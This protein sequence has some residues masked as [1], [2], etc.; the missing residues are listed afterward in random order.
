MVLCSGDSSIID[1]SPACRTLTLEECGKDE[2]LSSSE[3]T[4]HSVPRTAEA[5]HEPFSPW[6]FSVQPTASAPDRS[7]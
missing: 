7:K 1:S 2:N 3:T 4:S 6:F 5:S